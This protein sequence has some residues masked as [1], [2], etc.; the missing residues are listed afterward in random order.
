MLAIIGIGCII[1]GALAASLVTAKPPSGSGGGSLGPLPNP[2]GPFEGFGRYAT[3][4]GS[5]VYW[6]KNLKDKGPGSLRDAVSA[7]NRWIKFSVGGTINLNSDLIIT[8]SN[9]TLDGFS[10]PS[11]ITLSGKEVVIE[12]NANGPTTQG[13]NVIVQGLRFRGSPDSFR[14]WRNAHD[15]VVDHCSFAT[16]TDGDFDITEGAYN[17]TVSWNI[18]ARAAAEGKAQLIKYDTSHVSVHHNIYYDN[19]QRS[20]QISSALRV[21]SSGLKQ[22]DPIA[23]MRYNIVWD[24]GA[25]GG[26]IVRGLDGIPGTANV[27]SNLYSTT[28]TTNYFHHIVFY[29]DPGET[30]YIHAEGN[31]SI[32]DC[33]GTQNYPPYLTVTSANS[34][35]NSEEFPYEPIEGPVATDQVGRL[36]EWTMVRNSAGLITGFADDKI[37]KA[38]RTA[39]QI[40]DTSVFTE[41]WN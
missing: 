38:A 20:P 40:P 29:Q 5:T 41:P 17:I 11:A 18:I 31:V 26:T 23:D 19:I 13:S 15:I 9:L 2:S 21:Y 32:P 35:N 34:V 12:G 1:F 30:T 33:R 22:Q 4:G 39:I 37:E 7:S 36:S 10:A 3:G 27:V 6:V 28:K 14:I 25:V 16:A 8:A 24:F